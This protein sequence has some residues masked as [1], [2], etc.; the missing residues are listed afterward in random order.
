MS[1]TFSLNK[2]LISESKSPTPIRLGSSWIK[3]SQGSA[4]DSLQFS[5]SDLKHGQFLVNGEAANGFTWAQL[6]KG[7]V[8][9]LH[10]G[11]SYSPGFSI[12]ASLGDESVSVA[13][14]DA[15]L[16]FKAVNDKAVIS[17]KDF[18]LM[19]GGD[20]S[21]RSM[22]SL[23]DEEDEAT[24]SLGKDVY[25]AKVNGGKIYV[26]GQLLDGKVLKTFTH[27]QLEN[28]LVQ[29]VHD[30]SEKRPSL[31]LTVKDSDGLSVTKKIDFSGTAFQAVNDVATVTTSRV[32]LAEGVDV[33]LR[34]FTIRDSEAGLQTA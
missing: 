18:V 33:K 24:G 14:S 31:T 19:E 16:R 28:G 29:F 27:E 1:L 32:T 21:L 30:G 11:T 20:L 23:H 22:I 4:G 2:M 3:L 34:N 15:N 13:S 25:T 6:K 12:K 8:S 10:D 7:Q 17:Q 26:N 5:V 9:F